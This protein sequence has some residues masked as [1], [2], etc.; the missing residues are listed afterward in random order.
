[1]DNA[2]AVLKFWNSKVQPFEN[3]VGCVR[4]KVKKAP[5]EWWKTDWVYSKAKFP[6]NFCIADY[7]NPKYRFE[8]EGPLRHE[9]LGFG[10]RVIQAIKDLESLENPTEREKTEL[11][12]GKKWLKGFRTRA[13][14][15]PCL[16]SLDYLNK[17]ILAKIK[18]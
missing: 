16:K 14:R 18:A 10:S 5:W 3:K 12:A 4:Q 9:K 17:S 13:M 1:M 2:D 11:K 15:K 8:Y 6:W 7:K